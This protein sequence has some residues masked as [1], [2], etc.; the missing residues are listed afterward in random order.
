MKTLDEYIQEHWTDMRKL[1]NHQMNS[2]KDGWAAGM[3]AAEQE[4][5]HLKGKIARLHEENAWLDSQGSRK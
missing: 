5:K 1:D 3:N 2:F 4:I